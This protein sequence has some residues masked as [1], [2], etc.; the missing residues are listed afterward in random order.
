MA[1]KPTARTEF[2]MF[3]V[4]YEDGSQRSNRKV[5]AGLLGG[6]DGDEPARAEIEAQDRAISEKSGMPPLAIKSLSR[7]GK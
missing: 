5:D 2:V 6:L 3:D 7:S 4:V 1:R